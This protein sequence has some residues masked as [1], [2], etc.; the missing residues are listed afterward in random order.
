VTVSVDSAGLRAGFYP[1]Q[2]RVTA[3]GANNSPQVLRVDLHVLP[4]QGRLGAVV[5]PTGLIFVATAGASPGAQTVGISTTEPSAVEFVSQPID[6][7]W[8]TRAPD[9]GTASRASPG[10]IIVQPNL[11]GLAPGIYRAGLTVFT[12]NDGEQHP[13]RLLLVVLPAGT[14]QTQAGGPAADCTATQLLV[15]FASVFSNFTATAGW[16]SQTIVNVRDDCGNPAVGGTVILS[17][18]SGEPAL[19]LS[20]VQSGQYLGMW[21][22]SSASPQVVVTARGLWKGLQGQATAIAQVGVNPNPQLAALNQG[23]VVLGAGFQGGP[24]APGSIVSLFGQKLATAE[25]SAASLPLP[26]ALGGVKVLIGN[27]EAP[28]FYAGPGQVNAQVPADL[29][30]DR[31]LQALVETNGVL[32]APEPV[33]TS[34]TRPGIFTTAGSQGAILLANTPQLASP[35]TPA[36]PGGFIS[37]YCTGLGA[38]QPAVGSGEAGPASPLATVRTPVSVTIGG[39]A[40]TVTFAGL[41]PGFA[42]VYQVNAQVPAGV[43]AG[44][45]T[46]VVLTQGGFSSNIAT[47]AVR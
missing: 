13:V 19:A 2:I 44:D 21:R 32:S 47:I 8:V 11:E 28:L 24:L 40:A 37:I 6:G 31:Q 29:P 17:F 25:N 22:P 36:Q 1:G 43:A 38:T 4:P 23:G 5:R 27:Q 12:R 16:P 33:Q 30:A 10:R 45:A 39:Q 20:E 35:A 18:S 42:G 15:Q 46:P 3:A 34:A 7:P 41:A 26:R 14:V 9:L